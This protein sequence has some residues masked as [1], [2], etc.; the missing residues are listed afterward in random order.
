MTARAA[1]TPKGATSSSKK[2]AS[3]KKTVQTSTAKTS[4]VTRRE[5]SAVSE[6]P[7]ASCACG[8]DC[9]RCQQSGLAQKTAIKP[10]TPKRA[11]SR[12]PNADA[13]E[14][15]A[16]RLA[17]QLLEATRA[18][19]SV[20]D[21]QLEERSQDAAT[22]NAGLETAESGRNTGVS[23]AQNPGLSN[24]RQ[25]LRAVANPNPSQTKGLSNASSAGGN[26]A[27]KSAPVR[28]PPKRTALRSSTTPD[29]R[30]GGGR[31]LSRNQT[32][33]FE[34]A[35][36]YD[37]GAVR[38]H[39]GLLAADLAEQRQAVAFTYGTHI[40]LGTAAQAVSTRSL[41]TILAH[42]L[43]HVV[44]QSAPPQTAVAPRWLHPHARAPPVRPALRTSLAP[45]NIDLIPDFVEDAAGAVGNF[46]ARTYHGAVDVAA[47]AIE[48]SV[49][50]AEDIGEFAVEVGGLVLEGAEAV[51]DYFAPGLL[52]FLRGD[53]F[54]D[55]AELFCSGLDTL[56][57]LLLAPLAKID[58]MSVL[59]SVFRGLAAGVE[60]TYNAIGSTASAA[61]GIMI[62][63]LVAVIDI[64][65]DD[66]ISFVQ[67]L[68]DG[69]GAVFTALWDDI[70]KPVLEFLGDIGSGALEAFTGLVTWAWELVKPVRD[71]A[72]W[73]WDW[74][75]DK[76]DLAWEGTASVRTWLEEKAK[77]AWKVFLKLI[78]PIKTPLKVVGGII[79]LFSPL[80][81]ILVLTQILPP[82]W[83]KLKWLAQ[84]WQ[85]TEVVVWAREILAEEILP[86]LIGAVDTVKSSISS[87]ASMLAGAVATIARGMQGIVSLF[88]SNNCLK[89]VNHV[90]EHVA[91][92]FDRLQAWAENG[93]EGLA[94]AL[95]AV[96]EALRAIFQ[97]ILD[98]LVRLLVVAATPPL[99]PI[100]ITGAIWLLLPDEF[101]PSVIN[102]VLGLI[103]AFLSGFPAFLTGMGPL[104]S[105]LKSA[106]LGFLRHLR[107]GKGVDDDTRISATNKVANLAAGGGP[108]FIAGYVIG[109]LH[110]LIDGIIDPFK[111]L[112]M[113]FELIVTGL[114]VL[115]RVLAPYIEQYAGAEVTQGLGAMNQALAVPAQG[116]AT[117][118]SANRRP[119][120]KRKSCNWP[121]D[122]RTTSCKNDRCRIARNRP[123]AGQ[124]HHT[125]CGCGR[126]ANPRKH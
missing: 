101:K 108:Q 125:R 5:T 56:V 53:V 109:L 111:L 38:V 62:R 106:V 107:S 68:S 122:P 31:R 23:P 90:L 60:A 96:F 51:V 126:N 59:E 124:R 26:P 30:L 48:G 119:A 35:L 32:Q 52:G 69:V 25:R 29:R 46:G 99:L 36:E 64:W 13:A 58:I 85:G 55:L 57:N 75:V 39:Y 76:F 81:P 43:V 8:G 84:N 103:I 114:R 20:P 73:A 50:L 88:G 1:S 63:P 117:T 71:A 97:P 19:S 120:C 16:R 27:S 72:E 104:A 65:G 47:D 74:V 44:Q 92:Q 24:S 28:A 123:A 83:D 12:A 42:E 49:E 67:G 10:V 40:I 87:A 66:I 78:E 112:F 115:G 41:N 2:S 86:F 82:I 21:E 100:A 3:T 37:L 116:A 102:F 70:A 45:Q 33:G 79:L 18:A 95:D 77:A 61:L 7:R 121:N 113:M 89:S 14:R 98:F 15:E 118:A 94:G 91:N 9:P 105:V 4:S 11:V 80:G 22:A 6:K 93:F 17:P 110:G 34:P 54:D